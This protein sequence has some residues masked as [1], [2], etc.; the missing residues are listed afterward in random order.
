MKKVDKNTGSAHF[1]PRATLAAIGVKLRALD[2]LAP[3]EE[4]VRINQ[5]TIKHEPIEKLQY[6]LIT[7]M[8]GAQGLSEI[9]ITRL[10]ADPAL[11]RAVGRKS[12]ADQSVVKATLNACA[13]TNLAQMLQAVD[14]ITQQ[15]GLAFRRDFRYVMLLMNR[16]LNVGWKNNR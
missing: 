16:V 9:N 6:E 8:A 1:T 14:A 4:K 2:L 7:I 3:I 11:Q 10:P 5:K 13:S 12:C 15:H